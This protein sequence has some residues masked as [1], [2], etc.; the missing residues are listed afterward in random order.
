MIDLARWLVGDIA[1]V[2]AHLATLVKRADPAG[3]ALDAATDSALLLVAFDNGAQGVIHV[4]GIV[5]CGD[6]GQ[7]LQVVLHGWSGT[8]KLDASYLGAE[9]RGIQDSG[10]QYEELPTPDEMWG[11]V[12]RSLRFI[13]RFLKCFEEQSIGDRMFVDAI[14][15]DRPVAPSFYD[16]LKVQEVMDAAIESHESGRWVS[17]AGPGGEA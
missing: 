12:D 10:Q 11:D 15:E 16:G 3:R 2:S 7:E 5:H 8:L 9:L 13:T 17:L 4:S 14:L 6:R 1:R